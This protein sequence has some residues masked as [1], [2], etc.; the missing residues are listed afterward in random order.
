LTTGTAIGDYWNSH[1]DLKTGVIMSLNNVNLD[2]NFH[3]ENQ[4][5]C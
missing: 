5:A 4:T 3:M 2:Y 1:L